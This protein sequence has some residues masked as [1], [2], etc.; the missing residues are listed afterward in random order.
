MF[1]TCCLQGTLKARLKLSATGLTTR[2]VLEKFATVQ[3]LDVHLIR[4]Q[5]ARSLL[6]SSLPAVYLAIARH[7]RVRNHM[8]RYMQPE[9]VLQL[10]LDQLKLS[11]SVQPTIKITLSPSP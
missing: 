9:K 5:S 11:L 8:A 2:A 1:L 7:R 3:M 4:S 10:L 6:R